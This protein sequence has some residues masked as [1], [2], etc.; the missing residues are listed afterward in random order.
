MRKILLIFSLFLSFSLQAAEQAAELDSKDAARNLA[1]SA[2]DKV[3][4]GETLEGINLLKP[5]LVIP[6]AEFDAMIEQYKMRESMIK[7]RFGNIAGVEF[8]KEEEVGKS[9]FL[10][11]YIQKFERHMM[12]WRFYFYKPKDKWVLNT[13]FTDD[14]IKSLFED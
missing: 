2:M 4:G 8:I 6:S 13:F 5:Y 10:I 1:K 3:S 12:R 11:T 7:H 9:L 14:N